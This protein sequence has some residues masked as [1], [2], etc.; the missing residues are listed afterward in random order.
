MDYKDK[1]VEFLSQPENMKFLLEVETLIPKVKNYHHKKCINVFEKLIKE[2]IWEDYESN[3][4]HEVLTIFK[5]GYKNEKYFKLGI[6]LGQSYQ[7]CFYGISSSTAFNTLKPDSDDLESYS[8]D[9]KM[10]Q[11]DP[12]PAYKRFEKNRSEL[13]N[14][15]TPESLEGFFED[16][17]ETFWEFADDVKE[18]IEKLNDRLK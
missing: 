12:W 10:L 1:I 6:Y 2:K 9:R 16:W 15:F 8:S 14:F 11:S 4:A 18:H 5:T 17:S 7:N 3:T 13:F